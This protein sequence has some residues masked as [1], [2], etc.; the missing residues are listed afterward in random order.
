MTALRWRIYLGTR[1]VAAL[2]GRDFPDA[3]SAVAHVR[4]IGAYAQARLI[5]KRYGHGPVETSTHDP[6][7]PQ[8]RA[9]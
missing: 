7:D 4:Q 2:P 8:E 1:L 6:H 5:C 3:N 9:A